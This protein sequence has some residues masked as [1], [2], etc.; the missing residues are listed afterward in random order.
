MDLLLDTQIYFW[1]LKE[2]HRVPKRANRLI[3]DASRV[4]VSAASIWE[5]TI[6]SG[7]GKLDGEP[8][9]FEEAIEQSGFHALAVTARHAASV[10]RL[11]LH[12]KDPFDRLLVAQAIAE[13][14]QLVTA[15]ELLGLYSDQVIVV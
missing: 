4:Y 14:L 1:T 7:L 5:M 6:K 12:H 3:E 13:G 15:D 9:E 10:H 11:G 8:R 2:T